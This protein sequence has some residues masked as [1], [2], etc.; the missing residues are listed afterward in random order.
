MSFTIRTSI[1]RETSTFKNLGNSNFLDEVM[2][3]FKNLTHPFQINQPTRCKSFTSLLLDVY[4]SLNMFWAA[5]RPSSGAY[6]CINPYHANVENRV[7]SL[8]YFNIY[9][10][11]CNVTQFIYIWKLLYVFQVV[12]PPIIRSAYNCIYSIWYLSHRYCYLPLSWKNWNR[13]ECAVG[14]VRQLFHDSG[15]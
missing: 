6:N 7:R 1:W 3:M 12:L 4:V 10:T 14:G 9:P 5:P 11:R 2:D 8:Q 13:F 15:R